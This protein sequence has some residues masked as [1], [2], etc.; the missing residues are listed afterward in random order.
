MDQYVTASQF[1]EYFNAV[2]PTLKIE[3][4]ATPSYEFRHRISFRI[5]GTLQS[6]RLEGA[7]WVRIGFNLDGQNRT[8][9]NAARIYDYVGPKMIHISING[10]HR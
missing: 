3:S 5:A 1:V 7:G 6:C 4:L 8:A 2:S 10:L 9:H